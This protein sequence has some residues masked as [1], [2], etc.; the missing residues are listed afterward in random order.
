MHSLESIFN[1]LPK[2]IILNILL[3]VDISGIDIF[4]HLIEDFTD[5]EN[6]VFSFIS[7]KFILKDDLYSFNL[8][9]NPNYVIS[10]SPSSFHN[11]LKFI[12]NIFK[13]KTYKNLLNKWYSDKI[14]F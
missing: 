11:L 7:N 13:N 6:F 9:V 12:K 2:E 10:F 5:F 3:F 4:N 1:K 14:K 8:D